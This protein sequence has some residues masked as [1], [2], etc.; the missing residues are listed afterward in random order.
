MSIPI[1]CPDCGEA[2]CI[3]D[4]FAYENSKFER[5][6]ANTE[7]NQREGNELDRA[8]TDERCGR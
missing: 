8:K 5:Q 7:E 3:C 4:P 1:P 6:H 2:S